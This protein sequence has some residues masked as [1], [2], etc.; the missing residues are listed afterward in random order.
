MSQIH[1]L[2][3]LMSHLLVNSKNAKIDLGYELL[4]IRSGLR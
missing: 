4:E 1:K 2:V 3:A